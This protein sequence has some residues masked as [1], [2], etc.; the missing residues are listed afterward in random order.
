VMNHSSVIGYE[1]HARDESVLG[2][3]GVER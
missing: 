3:A 2:N 1:A